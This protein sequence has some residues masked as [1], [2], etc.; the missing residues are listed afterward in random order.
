MKS[1]KDCAFPHHRENYD[2]VIER[3]SEIM[4]AVRRMDGES[5][6]RDGT[7]QETLGRNR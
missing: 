7:G 3:F 5:D 4:D 1:C 2:R 6:E